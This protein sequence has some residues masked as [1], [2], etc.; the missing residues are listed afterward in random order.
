VRAG[1]AAAPPPL[2]AVLDPFEAPLEPRGAQP[3]RDTITRSL[4]FA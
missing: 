1:P 4:A 2:D 3:V